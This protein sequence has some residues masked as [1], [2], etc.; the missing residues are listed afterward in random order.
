MADYNFLLLATDGGVSDFGSRDCA[1]DEAA[2]KYGFALAGARSSVEI[3]SATG[4]VGILSQTARTKK[5]RA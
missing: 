5:V 3:W 1:N 4:L 2:M